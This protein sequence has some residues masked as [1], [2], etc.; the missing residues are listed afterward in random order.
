MTG[1]VGASSSL[2]DIFAVSSPLIGW[3]TPVGIMFN[4]LLIAPTTLCVNVTETQEQSFVFCLYFIIV[5][6]RGPTVYGPEQN[7]PSP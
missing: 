2:R 6:H 7:N 1:M 4:K 5:I 3:R